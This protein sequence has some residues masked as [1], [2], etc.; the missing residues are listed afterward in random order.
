VTII[1]IRVVFISDEI[2]ESD[3]AIAALAARFFEIGIARADARIDYGYAYARSVERRVSEAV[4]AA[5]GLRDSI[6]SHEFR[7]R[8]H[9]YSNFSV[10][11]YE[12]DAFFFSKL[13]DARE[14]HSHD[15]SAYAREP[16][17]DFSAVTMNGFRDLSIRLNDDI[18]NS[19]V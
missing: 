10:R 7:S 8:V 5:G 4:S 19:F 16:A 12:C 18:L 14:R 6:R 17:S 1:V 3:Y 11:S 13:F 15:R 9:R 2:F